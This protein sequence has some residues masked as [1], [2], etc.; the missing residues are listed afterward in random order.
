MNNLTY[1]AREGQKIRFSK[2]KKTKINIWH[3]WFEL[4]DILMVL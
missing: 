4:K 3:R 1:S 2:Y